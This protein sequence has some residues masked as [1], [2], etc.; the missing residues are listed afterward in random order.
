M[1]HKNFEPDTMKGDLKKGA[2][3]ATHQSGGKIP[4]PKHIWSPAGGWY[5]QPANWK[6]NTAVMGAVIIGI[7]AIA[8]SVSAEREV[9]TR[10]PEPDRFFPSRNWSRQIIEHERAQKGL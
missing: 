1:D 9:R 2:A 6:A 8:W 4:Y 7:T 5:S 10:F 3:A